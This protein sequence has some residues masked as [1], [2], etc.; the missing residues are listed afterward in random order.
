MAAPSL[1]PIYEFECEECGARFEEL[2]A[3]GGGS[4]CPTC[5]SERTRRLYSEV[6]PPGR[7]PRGAKVRSDESRRRERESARQQR[8]SE[9]RKRRAAG[10]K[11]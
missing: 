10:E 2:V 3:T 6:S 4:A 5:G 9:S 1:M 8:L 7:Q 11:P